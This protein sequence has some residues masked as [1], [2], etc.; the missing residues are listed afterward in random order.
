MNSD[1]PNLTQPSEESYPLSP[2]QEGMLYHHLASQDQ[3]VDVVQLVVSLRETIDIAQLKLAWERVIARHAVLRTSF[4]WNTSVEPKQIVHPSILLPCQEYNWVNIPRAGRE[5]YLAAF[6][7]EDRRRGIQMDCAPLWRLAL[8]RWES[9]EL[10]L[11]WTFHHAVLDGRSFLTV[12]REVFALY[13]A[14]KRKET[15]V[16]PVPRPYSDYL[17]W[18]AHRDFSLSEPFWRSLLQ[19]VTAPT[20]LPAD[21]KDPSGRMSKTQKKDDLAVQLSKELTTRLRIFTRASGITLNTLMQGVWALLLSRHSGEEEIV[22]GATRACRRTSVDGIESMVGLLINTLPVRVTVRPEV[23]VGPW[24]QDLR[25]QW[26]EMRNHE[27]SPL[28]K[29]QSCSDVPRNIPLFQSIV[30][31][32]KSFPDQALRTGSPENNREVSLF[33]QTNFPLTFAIHDGE[34]LRLQ[35]GYHTDQYS[36]GAVAC[37]MGHLQVLLESIS[38]Q[39]P[40]RLGDLPMLTSG[41]R[42]QILLDWNQTGK[43]YPNKRCVHE[44]FELQA[45]RT[46]QKV[47]LTFEGSNCSYAE[48]NAKANHVAHMLRNIGVN[49]GTSRFP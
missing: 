13:D 6:L 34:N 18:L 31:F 24:L 35:I 20:P 29:V 5:K 45:E 1:C 3:G 16:L 49:R 41:E 22:F 48:L 17:E 4:R 14:S 36:D 37:L 19:G 32:E 26:V 39:C 47:A 30:V 43:D 33:E 42:Y 9:D 2:L 27:H 40:Q 23:S 10:S 28:I 44:L 8:V 38:E 7:E 12:V 21:T 11:V 25:K 46:P 15:P